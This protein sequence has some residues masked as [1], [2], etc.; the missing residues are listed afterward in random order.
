MKSESSD[1]DKFQIVHL[2][3]WIVFGYFFPNKY[4][5][6]FLIMILWELGELIISNNKTL[7]DFFKKNWTLTSSKYRNET[8]TN[9]ILDMIMNVIGYYI[10]SN[11]KSI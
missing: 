10:G 9:K 4:E 8:L 5:L 6:A 2:I 3:E 11:M 1:I 7:Y